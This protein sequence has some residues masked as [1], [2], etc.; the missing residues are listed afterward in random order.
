ME[1]RVTASAVNHKV[2][3]SARSRWANSTTQY[4]T[5]PQL[6][7]TR[8]G[9]AR[10]TSRASVWFGGEPRAER[11]GD[12]IPVGIIIFCTHPHWPWGPP[13]LSYY[14]R[15]AGPLPGVKWSRRGAEVKERVELKLY[16]PSGSSWPVYRVNST[17]HV[18]TMSIISLCLLSTL[19]ESC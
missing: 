8:V 14:T 16:A 15:G 5:V 17:F 13:S 1:Y 10:V 6:N 4:L 7:S 9:D 11:Y 12:R 18:Q 19:L 2:Q 3:A